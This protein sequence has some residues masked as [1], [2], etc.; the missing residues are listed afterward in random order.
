M[1]YQIDKKELSTLLQQWMQTAEVFAPVK[2]GN[3]T[4]FKALSNTNELTLD[5]PHNTR[6]PP[7]SLFLPQSE[8]LFKYG[9]E[10]YTAPTQEIHKRIVFGIRP[11]DARAVTLL[12]T[13]FDN[14]EYPDPYWKIRREQTIL[15]G[16]GCAE[17]VETCFCTTVG[18]GPFDKTGLDVLA[19]PVDEM[20]VFEPITEKGAE[21]LEGLP[22]LTDSNH[23]KMLTVQNHALDYLKPAFETDN[24]KE[25]LYDIFESDYWEQISQPC[26]GCGICTFLCPTCFCFDI[27]DETQRGER[28]RNW[29]SCMFRVYSQEAS[30]HNPRPTRS[31]RTRQRIMHKYAYWL[32][33]IDQIGCTGC[34][35]C[36]R[37]CPAGIDIRELIRNARA[38]KEA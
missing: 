16:L 18:S 1:N 17:P 25:K 21:L 27:V 32:D 31:E 2:V 33:Q 8:V 14:H 15:V 3:F 10:G 20:Y 12:D 6:Y 5:G 28:V 29:D 34:G 26:L 37:Y 38:W 23:E 4:Q 36:I 35:R 19:T 11:C 13:V 7:K 24:I 30:G 22:A 9:K